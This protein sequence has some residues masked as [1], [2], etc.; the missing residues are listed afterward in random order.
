MGVSQI[1]NFDIRFSQ[2]SSVGLLELT[3]VIRTVR[4]L[5]SAISTHRVNGGCDEPHDTKASRLSSYVDS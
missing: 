1:L 3:V 4:F 5:C 2:I